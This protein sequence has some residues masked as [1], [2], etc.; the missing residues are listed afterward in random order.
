MT[1]MDHRVTG[2]TTS[3]RRTTTVLKTAQSTEP[4]RRNATSRFSQSGNPGNICS[5]NHTKCSLNYTECSL[6]HTECHQLLQ[7]VWLSR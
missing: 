5:L 7:I 4:G 3:G 1:T 6:K 2:R